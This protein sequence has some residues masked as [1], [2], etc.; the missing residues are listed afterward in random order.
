MSLRLNVLQCLSVPETHRRE[1]GRADGGVYL[2]GN[3][4]LGGRPFLEPQG[5]T[6]VQV[7]RK[8]QYAVE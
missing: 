5:G 7:P 4:R 1:F 2:R 8:K 6:G 3:N